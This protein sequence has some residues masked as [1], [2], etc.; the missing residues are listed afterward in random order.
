MTKQG[1]TY[2]TRKTTD[3]QGVPT[4]PDEIVVSLNNPSD[5]LIVDEA[6]PTKTSTG[7]YHYDYTFADD[8]ATGVWVFTWK[9]TWDTT[10]V[11]STES[12]TITAIGTGTYADSSDVATRVSQ[13]QEDI[14]G[15]ILSESVA[16][17]DDFIVSQLNVNGITPPASSDDLTR[18]S[19]YLA[20]AD[21]IDT[22]YIDSET[23]SPIAIA[24]EEKGKLILQNYI[25]EN[26]TVSPGTLVTTTSG[27]TY[28]Y[29]KDYE[30]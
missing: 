10:P 5:T 28:V 4:D 7:V 24:W 18:A 2:I 30:T 25:D 3:D 15:A 6:T 1:T 23:R 12:V 26:E 29:D 17:A 9:V 8:A 11:E 22:L 13:H 16:A 19:N 14:S 27:M 20:S 21:I